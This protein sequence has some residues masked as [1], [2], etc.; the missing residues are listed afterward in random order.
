[1]KNFCL[2]FKNDDL[3]FNIFPPIFLVSQGMHQ[4]SE[5]TFQPMFATSTEWENWLHGWRWR[6]SER[7]KTLSVPCSLSQANRSSRR[8]Q[9][10]TAFNRLKWNC[11]YTMCLRQKGK[12]RA[13][14]RA[15]R[16]RSINTQAN[17]MTRKP[18]SFLQPKPRHS[19]KINK[20]FR[21]RSGKQTTRYF[22]DFMFSNVFCWLKGFTLSTDQRKDR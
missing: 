7:T 10:G 14:E 21:W 3:K 13:S 9:P 2:H 22:L 5:L 1:M 16:S 19:R 18:V 6:P 12:R 15:L 11:V 8:K 20:K 17:S 4:S